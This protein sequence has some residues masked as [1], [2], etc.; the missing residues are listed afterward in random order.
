MYGSVVDCAVVLGA[1][2]VRIHPVR[3]AAHQ[4]PQ[5]LGEDVA[6][7]LSR[8]HCARGMGVVLHTARLHAAVCA[9]HPFAHFTSLHSV[10]TCCLV[11]VP[12]SEPSE[13]RSLL[14]LG[15]A[16]AASVEDS[17]IFIHVMRSSIAGIKLGVRLLRY[18]L[19]NRP[20]ASVEQSFDDTITFAWRSVF[21]VRPATRSSGAA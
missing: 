17:K 11:V 20:I 21:A 5:E 10:C 14:P 12:M 15:V 6:Q 1:P 4:V 7:F 9:P 3:E 16:P 19:C 13:E 18:E 2:S 8:R